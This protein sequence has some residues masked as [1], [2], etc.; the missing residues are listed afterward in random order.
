M[1]GKLKQLS[2]RKK[3]KNVGNLDIKLLKRELLYIQHTSR[4]QDYVDQND[5]LGYLS[6]VGYNNFKYFHV[7]NIMIKNTR[8]G[9]HLLLSLGNWNLQ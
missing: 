7:W 4:F 5:M 3:F 9:T 8:F 2:L 1:E 6:T